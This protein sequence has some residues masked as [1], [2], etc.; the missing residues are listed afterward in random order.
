MLGFVKLSAKEIV[1]L[2]GSLAFLS[3]LITIFPSIGLQIFKVYIT[4]L[5]SAVPYPLMNDA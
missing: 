2:D 3:F 5:S 4:K 1:N